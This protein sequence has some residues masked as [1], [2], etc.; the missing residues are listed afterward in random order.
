MNYDDMPRAALIKLLQEHDA[1]LAD[2]GKDGIVMSYAGRTAPWQIIRQVKPKLFDINA[3]QAK[4][5]RHQ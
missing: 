1:S 3:S 2:Q 5:L 4:T